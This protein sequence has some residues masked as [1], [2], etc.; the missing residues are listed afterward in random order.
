MPGTEG[1]LRA[2]LVLLAMGFLHPEQDLLDALRV[3]KDPRGNAKAIRP[4]TTSAEGV[5]AAGDAR[6][7][8][9]LIVWAINEGRQCARMVDRYLGELGTPPGYG[10][11]A[12]EGPAG[13]PVHVTPGLAA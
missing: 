13:P 5:F 11:E 7:G 3:E 10:G 8:Q 6:R 9:S 4:Y 1:E 12:D 2:E